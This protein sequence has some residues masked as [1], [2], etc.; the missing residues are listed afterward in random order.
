MPYDVGP[1]WND[2]PGLAGKSCH[3]RPGLGDFEDV[4]GIERQMA[5]SMGLERHEV[6]S[7]ITF[8]TSEVFM[9]HQQ[10][11]SSQ[12]VQRGSPTEKLV[13]VFV[14]WSAKPSQLTLVSVIAWFGVLPRIVQT[15]ADVGLAVIEQHLKSG[16][17]EKVQRSLTI[18]GY[19]C[20]LG[21]PGKPGGA[22][23]CRCQTQNPDGVRKMKGK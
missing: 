19:N 12:V 1:A 6:R 20:T 23:C 2:P 4:D 21:C 18:S 13:L 10:P 22:G 9:P 3:Y 5:Q 17:S 8:P 15:A 7:L 16:H 11:V 14:R